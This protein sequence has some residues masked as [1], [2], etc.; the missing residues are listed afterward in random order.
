MK[1]I[2]LLIEK[3]FEVFTERISF[4]L[5]HPL[6]FF[7]AIVI[8]VAWIS[9]DFMQSSSLHSLINDL[10]FS[11]TFLMVFILQKMQNKFS[12]VINIKLNELVASHENAS[13]RL[14][15]AEDMTE[16]ELRKL[17]SYYEK[18]SSTLGKAEPLSAASS[19]EHVIEE[20]GEEIEE[21][22]EAKKEV[23]EKEKK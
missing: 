4:F 5:G 13:N 9:I 2:I 20:M 12:T 18:L 3:K 21:L 17:A 6:C 11:F 7:A 19:I 16:T 23:L 10:I 15:K 8:V 14:I 1:K 22:E